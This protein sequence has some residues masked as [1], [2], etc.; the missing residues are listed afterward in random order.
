M[1]GDRLGGSRLWAT[2]IVAVM[3]LAV[4]PVVTGAHPALADRPTGA[5]AASGSAAGPAGVAPGPGPQARLAILGHQ[6]AALRN[7]G[8]S[9]RD[10]Y[11]PNYLA[12]APAPGSLVS[13]LYHHGPAPMGIGDYGVENATGTPSPYTLRSTSWEGSLTL[14]SV[15]S[16]YLDGDGPDAFG[17]QLN[18]VL[19][20][21]TVT[22]NSSDVFWT[23]NV[24]FYSPL[25]QTLQFL[26]NIWNFSDPSTLE[27]ASTF[28]QYNGT[29]VD[30]VF[31]YD[32]GPTFIVPMPF[33]I[34][35][36]LNSSV[37]TT[38]GSAYS[39]VTFGYD[40]VNGTGGVVGSGIYDTVL[41]NS[42]VSSAPT[43]EFMVNG[44][45]VTPTGYLLY[46]SE[47][48]IGGPGGG[49]TATIWDINGTESLRYLAGP[50][51]H[52][53]PAVWTSGTDTGETSEGISE[54]YTTPGTMQ[55]SPG[56]SLVLPMWNA[57]PGGHAGRA[58]IAGT[59]S[60]T[61]AF[62]FVDNGSTL[63]QT[64]AGWAPT[65]PGGSY[66]FSLPPGNYTVAEEMSEFDPIELTVTANASVVTVNNVSLTFDPS[67]GVYTPLF[68]WSNAQLAEISMSGSGTPSDPYVLYNN[69]YAPLD[70]LYGEMNDFFFPVF[71]AI[72]LAGTTAHVEIMDPPAFNLV[73]PSGYDHAL[74]TYG[75]PDENSL[76]IEAYQA[77]NI[78][79]WGAADI[80]GW[81]SSFLFGF[82]PFLPLGNVLFWSVSGSLIGANTFET[83]SSSVFLMNGG[84]NTIWGNHFLTAP[85]TSGM[86]GAGFQFALN[87]F[88]AGDLIY[89]NYVATPIPALSMDYNVYNGFPQTNLES[90]NLTAP[91][92]ATWVN[93]VNGQTLTG[94]IVGAPTVC[95]NYWSNYVAGTGLYTDGGFIESGGDYCPALVG[96]YPL[97]FTE[98]GLPSGTSWSVAVDGSANS[99]MAGSPITFAVPNG[100]YTYSAGAVS[101]Y[102]AAHPTGTVPIDGA[103]S[104][105]AITYSA[106]AAP[107]PSRYLVLVSETGLAPGTSWSATVDGTTSASNASAIAF[108]ATNGSHPWSVAAVSGYSVSASSGNVSVAGS[109]SNVGVVFTP[110]GGTIQGTVVPGTASVTVDGVAATV[111]A[112]TFSVSV[113]VGTHAIVATASGYVPYYNNVSVANAQTTAVAIHMSPST[114]ATTSALT[115]SQIA[116]IAGGLV[117]LAVAVILAALLLRRRPG[118][119]APVAASANPAVEAPKGP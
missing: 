64:W 94:S 66:S 110:A 50:T 28:Y 51:Y 78:T 106:V 111:T 6:L 90:W 96:T 16:L 112:G 83:Q 19:T 84:G 70:P 43:P 36:Y 23:Q 75:L 101:G 31:Y 14:N 13:P 27:P 114:S 44:S 65:L 103:G 54:Y 46:D 69:Q 79:L 93:V 30:P 41:F 24:A 59:L 12:P 45:S 86:L 52:N 89:N 11:L 3:V 58:T 91:V 109:T 35:L 34:D 56:P 57:T 105:V 1:F 9:M 40:V 42:N 38:N 21:V 5:P 48:M 8:V 87:A 20:N 15:N 17:V 73:Y 37:T 100:S 95:G 22:G 76:Q 68:A 71:P 60:P 25:T 49:S 85:T 81:F 72:F 82:P 47:I 118:A 88:E 62:V 102:S 99:A 115:D 119:G 4:A 55:L 10:V 107:S 26:D 113:G 104:S 32:L 92:P 117:V 77:S 116:V 2:L 61:N 18:T 29:P 63:N 74:T 39:T 7:A 80:T 33:T 97:T 108:Q 98:S 53:D 67:M